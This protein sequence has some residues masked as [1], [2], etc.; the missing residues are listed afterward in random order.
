MRGWA[1]WIGREGGQARTAS[2]LFSPWAGATG[3]LNVGKSPSRAG[4]P[5]V[6]V[7]GMLICGLRAAMK[8]FR[9]FYTV[10]VSTAVGPASELGGHHAQ[11]GPRLEPCG[12][13]ARRL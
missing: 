2:I 3:V 7:L 8:R 11:A 4:F 6:S 1:S 13:H 5:H 12:H 10:G 9:A